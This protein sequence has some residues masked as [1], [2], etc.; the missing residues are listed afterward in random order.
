MP[1]ATDEG[2]LLLVDGPALNRRIDGLVGSPAVVVNFW[3]TWCEPCLEEFPGFVSVARAYASKEVKV[4][5][6]SMDFPDE[7]E[8][9][10]AFLREAGASLPSYLRRGKDH[11]FIMT[12]H[13]SWSGALPATLIYGSKK[14]IRYFWE[15]KV[16]EAQLRKALDELI[17]EA[18]ADRK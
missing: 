13:S 6:V 15:G 11:D 1:D 9:V 5:F 12:V 7:Q 14:K 16:D 2:E 18:S 3:A 8:P 10:L 17:A 4:L